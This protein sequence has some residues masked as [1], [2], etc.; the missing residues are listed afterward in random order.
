MLPAKLYENSRQ[1]S[2][3]MTTRKA[4]NGCG[5]NHNKRQ[6]GSSLVSR[7]ELAKNQKPNIATQIPTVKVHSDGQ[8]NVLKGND[9]L[10]RYHC[11]LNGNHE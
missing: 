6:F 9:V 11:C 7:S 4:S 5:Q 8:N 1:G 3:V 2:H 10:T